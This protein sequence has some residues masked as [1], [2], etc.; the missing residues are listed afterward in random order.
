M[1]FNFPCKFVKC[2]GKARG[3]YGCLSVTVRRYGAGVLGLVRQ[4]VSGRQLMR[5]VSA[6]ER[7]MPKVC[8]HAAIVANRPNRA[9]SSFRR[10]CRF[11]GR[12]QFR[13]VN[14]FTCSRRRKACGRERCMSDVPRSIGRRQTL[15]L[16]ELRTSVCGSVGALLVKAARGAVVSCESKSCFINQDRRDAPVT[17]PGVCVPCSRSVGV[18]SFCGIEVARTEKGSVSNMVRVWGVSVGVLA[19]GRVFPFRVAGKSGDNG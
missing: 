12:V 3:I 10:L 15:S 18:N 7:E 13:Q 14:M 5:L 17:S 1:S 19:S 11:M 2:S 9:S 4:T 6:V 8:L 16:V